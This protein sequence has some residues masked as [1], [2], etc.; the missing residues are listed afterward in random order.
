[1][2]LRQLSYF[3][4]IAE[5]GSFS[6]GSRRCYVSQSAISQQIKLLEEELGMSL[7]T[8]SS[9]H[10]SL[11]EGGKVLYPLAKKVLKD[12]EECHERISDFNGML[13][14]HLSIGLTFSLEPHIRGAVVRFIRRYPNVKLNVWY[15]TLPELMRMLRVGEIDMAFGIKV[16]GEEE[17][18]ESKPVMSYRL[19]AVMRD[20]HPL[21]T[22]KQLSFKDLRLQHIVLPEASIRDQNAAEFY[23]SNAARVLQYCTHVNSPTAILSILRSSNCISIL[24]E[25]IVKGTIGL[26]AISVEELADSYTSYVYFRK[27]AYRKVAGKAFLD[28]LVDNEI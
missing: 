9:H 10:L 24:P 23:L 6:E 27:N 20:T 19:C 16:E 18:V 21:S 5:C 17:W 7:F 8:R 13:S 22:R 25:H 14:G 1:M 4:S 3:V 12:V 15:K 2:E 26:C 11:T 28:L